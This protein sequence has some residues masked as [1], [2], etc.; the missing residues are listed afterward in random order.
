MNGL[1]GLVLLTGFVPLAR[2]WRANRLTA[3]RYAV[4]WALA[5][6]AAWAGAAAATAA[7]PGADGG[8]TAYLAL[9]LTG[10]AGVAVLG[11]RRPGAGAWNFVVAG[12]LAVLLLPV[13]RG[14]GVP[15]P[16]PW[17]LAFLGVTLAVGLANYLP[18]RLSL[19][20][21]FV[22]AGCG[23]ELARL[24]AVGPAGELA[25]RPLLALAPWVGWVVVAGAPAPA[26]EFDRLWLAYR[27]R[28][29]L[30]WGQRMREQ[31]NRAAANA[32]WPVF[33]SWQGLASTGAG[34]PP[35]AA[36]AVATLQAVLKR[37][38]PEEGGP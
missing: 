5:A 25:G 16:E 4:G 29:G 13:A 1:W 23:V 22:A 17:H 37:F 2:A 11:A 9:C 36:Q 3:L 30:V 31:F 35:P 18:T 27:D 7:R 21:L 38:G 8:L 33:L 6:W 10:C 20:V 14:L 15:K 34:A 19:A 32:G 12:L 28:F 24:A 26:A